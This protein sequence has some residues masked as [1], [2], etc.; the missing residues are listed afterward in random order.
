MSFGGGPL[1]SLRRAILIASVLAAAPGLARALPAGA[2]RW[3]VSGAGDQTSPSIDASRVVYASR[4]PGGDFDVW[5]HDLERGG[6]TL[7]AGGAG[8]QDWPDIG[9][10][11]VVYRTPTGIEVASLLLGP[12]RTGAEPGRAFNPVI[13]DAV[14]A[15][16]LDTAGPEG[17][18][19]V[20]FRFHPPD[21]VFEGR[22]GGPG[23]QRSPAAFGP[24]VA[25][26]DDASGGAVQLLD[27]LSGEQ[28]TFCQGVATGVAVGSAGAAPRIAVA[29]AAP[30]AEPDIEVYDAPG[31]LRA[32]LRVRGEQRNPH[33]AGDWVAFEDLS[34]G[35]SQ[36]VLWNF[37][38][39]VAFR[40]RPSPSDQILND[41]WVDPA[42]ELRVVFADDA[43]GDLD[44]ALY[45]LPLP[46]DDDGSPSN[47]PTP[48]PTR[49]ADCGDPDARL[50]ASVRVVREKGA[51]WRATVPVTAPAG[52]RVLACVDASHV[53][54]A[55]AELDG[56]PLARP[57]DFH[58]GVV[59][60]EIP[61]VVPE[62]A[63]GVV[64]TAQ[65][66]GK[67]GAWVKVRLVEDPV[68]SPPAP[69]CGH[70]A[71]GVAALAAVALAAAAR[72]RRRRE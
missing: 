59:H 70:G 8:D 43:P 44:V 42:R 35:Q 4:P 19:I 65:L 50:V 68:P 38:T 17:R 51:P 39:G 60:L 52:T 64:L 45:T 30:G 71:P 34:S 41:V 36:V 10:A 66:A 46:Y 40:P 62:A 9:R 12:L 14:A 58:V 24:W 15:W 21:S 48:P 16:E 63:G 13:S 37:V 55:S 72:G 57:S 11:M 2:F 32:A 69:G 54:S 27:T 31:V 33:L 7:I 23:D 28:V 1:L 18:E 53:T 20:F 3:I 47:W 29:R 22:A 67:P 26:V 6:T 25:Y 61:A 56:V 5:V 49:P